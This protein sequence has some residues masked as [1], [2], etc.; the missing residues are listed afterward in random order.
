MRL[1]KL[2]VLNEE[3]DGHQTVLLTPKGKY[4][5]RTVVLWSMTR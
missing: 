1:R 2:I 5:Y 4:A 3:D